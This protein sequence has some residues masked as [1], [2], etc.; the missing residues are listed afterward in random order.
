MEF[1]NEF[2]RAKNRSMVTCFLFCIS[3]VFPTADNFSLLGVTFE[4][5]DS[6]GVQLILLFLSTVA[7]F[8][9]ILRMVEEFGVVR[10]FAAVAS[11]TIF[12]LRQVHSDIR[13]QIR[14]LQNE[15][16]QK[17]SLELRELED[18]MKN[19]DHVPDSIKRD[20]DLDDFLRQMSRVSRT[21]DKISTKFEEIDS[22]FPTEIIVLR[23]RFGSR[24]LRIWLDFLSAP[25]SYLLSVLVYMFYQ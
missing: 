9:V 12:E 2:L 16:I 22:R 1:S 20:E 17:L 24:F 4:N 7:V 21:F 5:L 11:D 19:E 18:F 6:R 8:A 25:I 13:Q 23:V 15:S 14:S 10:G 3:I